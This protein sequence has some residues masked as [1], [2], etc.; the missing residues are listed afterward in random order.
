[1][2]GGDR[3]V[4]A[5]V[6]QHG[7]ADTGRVAVAAL[8]AVRRAEV[9]CGRVVVLSPIQRD[10]HREVHAAIGITVLAARILQINA[11]GNALEAIVV[12]QLNRAIVA[13]HAPV[14]LV[15]HVGVQAGARPQLLA[16]RQLD[17]FAFVAVARSVSG[18]FLVV[19]RE[20]WPGCRSFGSQ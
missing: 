9:G 1:M 6:V 12:A 4:H 10:R 19:A 20:G 15:A 18:T 17:A 2:P 11:V 8:L 16:E 3:V 7:A 5:T 13:G 14:V